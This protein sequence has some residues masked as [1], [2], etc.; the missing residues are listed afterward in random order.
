MKTWPNDW[1]KSIYVPIYKKEDKKNVGIIELLTQSHM[2][3]KY[4]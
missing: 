3:A 4:F 1:K 2:L